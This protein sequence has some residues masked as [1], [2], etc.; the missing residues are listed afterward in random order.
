MIKKR[1]K[2]PYKG[3][4]TLE[5]CNPRSGTPVWKEKGYNVITNLYSEVIN[6][7]TKTAMNPLGIP[8]F[9]YFSQITPQNLSDGLLLLR[10]SQNDVATT[11][12]PRGKIT[13]YAGSEYNGENLERGSLNHSLTGEIPGVGYQW[14]Y[15][16]QTERANG[17][18]SSVGLTPQS[19]G[20]GNF[21]HSQLGGN[22]F[23]A[24]NGNLVNNNFG[25]NLNAID[26]VNGDYVYYRRPHV[27]PDSYYKIHKAPAGYLQSYKDAWQETQ[28][29]PWGSGF[30]SGLWTAVGRP[31]LKNNNI[32]LLAEYG[33]PVVTYLLRLEKDTGEILEY[34]TLGTDTP[35][36]TPYVSFG[37]TNTHIHWIF[38]SSND[39][40]DYIRSFN[41]NT[42]QFETTMPQVSYNRYGKDD[43]VITWFHGDDW[44]CVMGSNSSSGS[45]GSMYADIIYSNDLTVRQLGIVPYGLLKTGDKPL[46]LLYDGRKAVNY[47]GYILPLFSIRNLINPVEKDDTK[48]LKVTYRLLYN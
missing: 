45:S 25:K 21:I 20:D 5:L 47:F 44:A 3:E 19:V 26:D 12:T 15:E 42:E 32:W 14:V 1:N 41:L 16:W 8:N 13:G 31:Q 4:V 23:Y 46:G 35:Y 11:L 28:I 40:E 9:Q 24:A 34:W 18:I 7:F 33:S 43:R 48:T 27:T 10:D 17:L 39:N 6:C 38:E 37:I 36:I 22:S 29:V 30:D 2:K